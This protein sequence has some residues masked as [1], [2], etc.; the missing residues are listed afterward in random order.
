MQRVRHSAI[1]RLLMLAALAVMVQAQAAGASR[2]VVSSAAAPAGAT[3]VMYLHLDAGDFPVSTLAVKLLFDPEALTLEEAAALPVLED[4]GKQS[5]REQR[6][7]EL[8]L[9][10]FGADTPIPVRTP[11]FRLVA[12]VAANVAPGAILRFLDAG[13]TAS[14]SRAE[15]VAISLSGG[16]VFVMPNTGHHSADSSRDWRIDLPELLRAV[17]LYAVGEYA[18]DPLAPD[19]FTPGPGPRDCAPHAADYTPRDWSIRFSELLRVIQLYNAPYRAYHRNP[20][21]ED[22]FTPGPVGL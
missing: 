1:R 12:R 14:D 8:A 3:F 10:V 5:D 7:G 21:G 16:A 20:A 4:A 9:A 19:G 11:F 13:T 15:E 18:C 17:Q 22:G 6:S 2:L